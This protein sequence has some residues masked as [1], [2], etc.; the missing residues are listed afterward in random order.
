M[1]ELNKLAIKYGADK[2]SKKH[3]YTPVYFSLFQNKRLEVKK[4]LEIGV[5]EGASIHMWREFFPNAMIYGGDNQDNRLHQEERIQVFKCDQSKEEDLLKLI[6]NTGSDIDLFVDD[7]SHVPIHQILTCLT[8]MPMLKK[9]VIYVIEDVADPTII[10]K[11][12]KYD[13]ELIRVGQR[14]DDQ[15]LIV[16]HK[17]G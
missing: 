10:E 16:K 12:R 1:D 5:A 9:N 15:L 6:E 4:V 14:Y 13:C 8:L 7:G 11:L 3:H 2:W 17:N